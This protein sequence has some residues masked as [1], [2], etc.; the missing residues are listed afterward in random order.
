MEAIRLYLEIQT[1]RSC[2]TS[3]L[4]FYRH[5]RT[6]NSS[7]SSKASCAFMEA[8]ASC[9]FMEVGASYAFMVAGASCVL[10]Q[11]RAATCALPQ[12]RAATC[13]LP[14]LKADLPPYANARLLVIVSQQIGYRGWLPQDPSP[15]ALQQQYS[16]QTCFLSPVGILRGDLLHPTLHSTVDTPRLDL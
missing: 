13:A 15:G 14:Q 10:P 16:M 7:D 11:L 3:F 6:Q 2:F 8:G 1:N 5:T 12:V 4:L 9:A